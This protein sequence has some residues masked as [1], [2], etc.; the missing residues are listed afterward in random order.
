MGVWMIGLGALGG[1]AAAAEFELPYT[2]MGRNLVVVVQAPTQP[3][4]EVG[5]ERV[6]LHDDGQGADVLAGDGLWSGSSGHWPVQPAMVV[7]RLDAGTVVEQ[8]M[9]LAHEQPRILAWLG[10][11]EP[12][13]VSLG[14]S[15]PGRVAPGGGGQDS[16]P[17]PLSYG[18]WL[19]VL[20]LAGLAGGLW[21][22]LSLRR[23]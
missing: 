1:Q 21:L 7:L 8:S 4:I 13:L 9:Q 11:G 5:Q 23:A 17:D 3:M 6:L 10:E 16:A 22:G 19:A 2:P 12:V 14:V 20:G 15:S 18:V